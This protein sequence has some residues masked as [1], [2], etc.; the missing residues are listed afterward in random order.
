MVIVAVEEVKVAGKIGGVTYVEHKWNG[1][2][3]LQEAIAPRW[4][5]L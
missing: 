4:R 2:L 3:M 1:K 5:S